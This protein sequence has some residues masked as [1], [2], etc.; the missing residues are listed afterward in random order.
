MFYLACTLWYVRQVPTIGVLVLPSHPDTVTFR[1]EDQ[2]DSF[3]AAGLTITPLIPMKS[4]KLQ[5]LGKLR[6]EIDNIE[7]FLP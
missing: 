3:C 4:W 7:I 2:E 5:F 6:C 1:A